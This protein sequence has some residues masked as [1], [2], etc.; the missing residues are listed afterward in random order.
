LAPL[1]VQKNY[2]KK[3]L[4]KIKEMN[5]KNIILQTIVF[6]FLCI[7]S[8]AEE[9]QKPNVVFIIVDD[10]N[11]WIGVMGGHPQ[12][13]TPNLDSLAEDGVLFTNAHCNAPQ[14]GPSRGSLL[15]GL[16]PKSTGRYFNSPKRMPFYG[17]QP[18]Q[19]ITSPN[20]PKNPFVFH[21]HFKE[22]GY[23]VVCGGKVAHG[24]SKGITNNVE[25]YLVRH[26]IPAETLPMRRPI[27]GEKE[28]LTITP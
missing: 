12:T 25:E 21:Q 22:H 20:A 6:A 23:R 9:K 27:Y 10:L 1:Q 13:K 17:D 18:T 28:G 5:K 4:R 26:L 15:H 16:Y 3:L 7:L 14:C 11:D 19:G 24:N 8:F 2:I